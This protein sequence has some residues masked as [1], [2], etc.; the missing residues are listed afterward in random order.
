MPI[1]WLFSGTSGSG[2]TGLTDPSAWSPRPGGF[3]AMV[4]RYLDSGALRR[5]LV[6]TSRSAIELFTRQWALIPA[7]VVAN[8]LAHATSLVS[9]MFLHGGLE[10]I[11]GNMLYLWIFGDNA[12]GACS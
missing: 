5:Q 12:F 2:G 4:E 3:D 11:A 8:P 7:A 9:H 10:H 6:K 1:S